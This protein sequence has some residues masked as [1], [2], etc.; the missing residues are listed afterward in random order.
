LL[1][2]VGSNRYDERMDSR[3][4]MKEQEARQL[5]TELAQDTHFP[6][7]AELDAS[8]VRADGSGYCVTV[9]WQGRKMSVNSRAEW[10]SIK[11]AWLGQEQNLHAGQSQTPVTRRRRSRRRAVETEEQ[12]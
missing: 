8:H 10:V 7:M 11:Q 12:C 5:L 4:S 1:L 9:T 2:S 6:T 3:P